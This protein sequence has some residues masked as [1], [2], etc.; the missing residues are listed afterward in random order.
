MSQN[1][2]L[3]ELMS[4]PFVGELTE[5]EHNGV[6][7]AW[8]LVTNPTDTSKEYIRMTFNVNNGEGHQEYT[9]NLFVR[10]MSIA[11]SHLRRQ[12]NRA[13]E[14]IDPRAFLNGLRDNKTELKLWV[15]YPIVPA[16]NGAKRVQNL[17]FQPP[18]T[19][20]EATVIGEMETPEI[21][22]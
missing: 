18:I 9:R 14:V 22:A 8:T 13:N 7:T 11:L 12:L 10:D 4:K 5:G 6:L 15:T 16:R 20:D 3:S 17:Y 2:S 19:A 21:T 1:L